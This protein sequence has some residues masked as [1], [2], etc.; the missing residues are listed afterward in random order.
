MALESAR[1]PSPTN[2]NFSLPLSPLEIR[3]QMAEEEEEEGKS[4]WREREGELSYFR[5]TP[6]S[7]LG[8]LP[9]APSSF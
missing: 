6:L 7:R 2:P 3:F 1:R 4:R 5:F 8:F 9:P